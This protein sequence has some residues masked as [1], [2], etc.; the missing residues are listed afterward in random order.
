MTKKCLCF[1]CPQKLVAWVNLTAASVVI[2]HDIDYNPYNDKQAEDRCHRVGQTKEVQVYKLL[3]KNSIDETMLRI[4]Q[5]KINIGLDL[6]GQSQDAKAKIDMVSL[7]K[8][9][10][11]F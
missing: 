10:L 9:A 5:R 3:S 8:E 1:C 11:K 7:L 6:S 4:Q 2:L